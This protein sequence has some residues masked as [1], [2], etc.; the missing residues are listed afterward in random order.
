M[1]DEIVE[2]LKENNI[3]NLCSDNEILNKYIGKLII[4]NLNSVF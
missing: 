2:F 3:E 4:G 1:K